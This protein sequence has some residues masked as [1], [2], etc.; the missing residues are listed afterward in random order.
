MVPNRKLVS[1]KS[2]LAAILSRYEKH[3][4][5]ERGLVTATIIC[6]QPVIRKFLLERFRE[7]PDYNISHPQ[8]WP[9]LRL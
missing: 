2:P 6:Y 9:G 5:S 1:D 3:L 7:Q 8:T 4:R